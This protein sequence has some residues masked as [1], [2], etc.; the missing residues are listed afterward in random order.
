M[1]LDI[2]DIRDFYSS[3]LGRVVARSVEAAV[4]ALMPPDPQARVLGFGFATPYLGRLRGN[5]ERVLA[6][7][8]AG[9]GVLDWPPDGQSVTALVEE[10]ALPLPDQSMDC[11]LIVHALEMS[12]KPLALM[13]E[14]RRVLTI[15]GKLIV[16]VPNRQGAW[17]RFDISPFGFGQPYSRGQLRSL[18]AEAG[19]EAEAWA[20]ALHMPP[21]SSTLR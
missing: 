7:M 21:F 8:P 17:S 11:V 18:F 10:D 3:L 19:F 5:C 15:G 20:T 6:F 13:A 16:V 14:A 4:S 12:P 9:Q 1:Y 2:I